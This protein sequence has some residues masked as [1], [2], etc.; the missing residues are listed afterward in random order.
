MICAVGLAV[1]LRFRVRGDRARL[2]AFRGPFAADAG[3]AAYQECAHPS[4]SLVSLQPMTKWRGFMRV[5]SNAWPGDGDVVVRVKT[6]FGR[7]LNAPIRP[8][9]HVRGSAVGP[10]T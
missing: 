2:F 6:G 9:L 1:S 3:S 5:V 8:P 10:V 7:K 4:S